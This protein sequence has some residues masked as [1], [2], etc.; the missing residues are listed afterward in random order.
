[1]KP[2]INIKFRFVDTVNNDLVPEV[3]YISIRLKNAVHLCGC[4]CGRKVYTPLAPNGW[5]LTFDGVSVSLS[6]S[7]CNWSYPCRS[8][9][10]IRNN[11]LVWV[12]D[13]LE[14]TPTPKNR[15][16]DMRTTLGSTVREFWDHMVHKF[17]EAISSRKEK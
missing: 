17:K 16:K 5:A 3:L 4:G 14:V 15:K 12:P 1:M 10:W 9:Y 13:H 2:N 8:H 6:P 11:R 7:V